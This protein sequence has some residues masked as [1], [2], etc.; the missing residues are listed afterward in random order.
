MLIVAYRLSEGHTSN[1]NVLMLPWGIEVL[2]RL[3]NEAL[4]TQLNGQVQSNDLTLTRM[5][6]SDTHMA[7]ILEDHII[8]ALA[9]KRIKELH[10]EGSLSIEL[11][12]AQTTLHIVEDVSISHLDRTLHDTTR[13]ELHTLI[14]HVE[15]GTTRIAQDIC[16]HHST[17]GSILDEDLYRGFID[18]GLLGITIERHSKHHPDT[19]E[20]EPPEAEE[21][22]ENIKQID[23]RC[24]FT[25]LSR[26]IRLC[27]HRAYGLTLEES[28]K[29][30]SRES[31]REG[32]RHIPEGREDL[33]LG[34]TLT[35]A[36]LSVDDIILLE[37]EG[38]RLKDI[39][40][41]HV[42]AVVDI[43]ITHTA[44]DVDLTEVSLL[45]EPPDSSDELEDIRL[46]II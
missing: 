8:D 31:C 32:R 1:L 4:F 30:S 19:Q 18:I 27:R 24:L 5:L 2:T 29:G 11:D 13:D 45:G 39:L 15:S 14:V 25:G 43:L 6:W 7:C 46:S 36:V 41:E 23:L 37:I 3:N 35:I 38:G 21:V 22:E 12:R 9:L 28:N 34:V 33:L 10:R 40:R 44:N 16:I 20:V 42:Q 17:L 26:P